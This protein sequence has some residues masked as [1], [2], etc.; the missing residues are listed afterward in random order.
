MYRVLIVDDETYVVDWLSSL[1]ESQTEPEELDVCR[2]YSAEEALNWL[3]RAKIDIVITDICMPK[4]SGIQLAE[5]VN[6]NWPQCKVI[7]LT[8]HAEFDYAY[9][10]IKNNVVSYILKTEDDESILREVNKTVTIL[11]KELINL[12][13]LD[14]IEEKSK[15][16]SSE[17]EKE[18]FLGIF[19]SENGDIG[20]LWKQLRNIG[21]SIEPQKHFLLLIGRIE[22]NLT[23]E[24]IVERFRKLSVIKKIAEHYFGEYFC[25]YPV[26]YR[27]NRIVWLMQ[28]KEQEIEKEVAGR[29][30][31][32]IPGKTVVFV[33]G[34]LET[35][36]HSCIETLGTAISFVMHH[37]SLE[38]HRLSETFRDLNRLLNFRGPDKTGFIISDN[39][40]A[41]SVGEE[42][43][44]L[45]VQSDI[46]VI[47][48]ITEKLK[49]YLENN[50]QEEF[51]AELDAICKEL[52][53]CTSWHSHIAKENYY[54]AAIAIVSH[55]NQRKIS[56][57]IAFKIGINELFNPHSVGSWSNAAN[58]LRRLSKVIF[59]IQE[60]YEGDLS[61]NT[62]RFLKNYINEHIIEDI[63]LVKLS[64]VTG[65]N[66][67]Y[68]SRFF[69]ENTGETLNDYISLRKLDKIKELMLE[70]GLNISEIAIKAGFG[71]RTYFNRF[72][73]KASGM[74]PQEFRE[75][76]RQR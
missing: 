45:D 19:E 53:K 72:M 62:I 6:Q 41:D 50:R 13:L 17:L 76:I 40:V 47:R 67:S 29:V 48:N 5:K 9:E 57:K 14:D 61:N 15:K 49:N 4:M 43:V 24:N 33:K 37:D 7:L 1:L 28:P 3:N 20:D 16:S 34:M 12:Q 26:E 10:A 11:D 2:A 36:Q 25:C 52:D 71:S 46:H 68:I 55:I 22:N 27:L 8:A 56:S 75:H 58:Y 63:S 30:Q 39:Y 54:S 38:A 74:S 59:D 42:E 44:L 23:D 66:A 65:Y 31:E 70:E 64:E 32:N 35:I 21:V 73:K 69:K 60:E 51:M 18:I